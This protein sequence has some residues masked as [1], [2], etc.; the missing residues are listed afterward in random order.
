ME[1]EIFL[2]E[3]NFETAVVHAVGT[4]SCDYI[5]FMMPLCRN[6]NIATRAWEDMS[7]QAGMEG[8]PAQYV[9]VTVD[10]FVRWNLLGLWFRQVYAVSADVIVYGDTPS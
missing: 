2:R 9:N 5:L 3:P 7:R 1:T 10:D 6:P 8:R 4:A